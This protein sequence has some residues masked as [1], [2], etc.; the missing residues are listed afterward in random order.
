[1]SSIQERPQELGLRRSPRRWSASNVIV[2]SVLFTGACVLTYPTAGD[3]VSG[4]A[5]SSDVSGYVDEVSSAPAPELESL[6][7]SAHSYNEALPQGPLRDPYILNESGEAVNLEDGWDTYL[8]QLSLAPMLPMARIMI[9]AIDVDLP[10]FH[11]TDEKVL[12]KGI[13]HLFGSGLPVGGEGTHA[14]LTGHSGLP[15]ATLFTHLGELDE[16]DLFYIFVAGEKLAYRIDQIEVVLPD[17][18]EDLRAV[19]GH[20]YVTLLTCTPTGVNTHRLLVRGERVPL[21]AGDATAE[22]VLA[23]PGAAAGFPWWTLWLAGAAAAAVSIAWPRRTDAA[24]VVPEDES[25]TDAAT[26]LTA[27]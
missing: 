1:M 26:A 6:L 24:S 4:I 2:A 16:G 7:E 12:D 20:D 27:Q 25:G 3:W 17:D 5:H 11:G 23:A 22:Q 19:A 14:V 10:V 15:N 21:D 8:D 18:G 13:G 9:P